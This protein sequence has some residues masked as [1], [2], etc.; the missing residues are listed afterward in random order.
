MFLENLGENIIKINCEHIYHENC[1]NMWF[2]NS[3]EKSCPI[4]RKKLFCEYNVKPYLLLQHNRLCD[5]IINMVY[6]I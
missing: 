5:V 1:I 2:S 6:G 3:K 4:C